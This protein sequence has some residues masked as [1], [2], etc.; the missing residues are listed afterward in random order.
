MIMKEYK[1]HKRN[2][3]NVAIMRSNLE[4]L[5][6]MRYEAEGHLKFLRKYFKENSAIE[7]QEYKD[8]IAFC[9]KSERELEKKIKAGEKE[10]DSHNYLCPEGYIWIDKYYTKNGKSINGHCRKNN[11]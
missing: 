4:G 8:E 9:R 3:P 1:I 6:R 10:W 7:I 5:R 11:K 2:Y